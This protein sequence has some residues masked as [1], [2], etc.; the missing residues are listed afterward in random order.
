MQKLS[1]KIK[2]RD[3]TASEVQM[4]LNNS[5][6]QLAKFSVS[7]CPKL[8]LVNSLKSGDMYK[9]TL[10]KEGKTKLSFNAIKEDFLSKMKNCLEDRFTDANSDVIRASAIANLAL[11]P[12][13]ESLEDF[14]S[15]HVQTLAN[16]F[17]RTLAANG[18]NSDMLDSEWY[19][20]K[21][22]VKSWRKDYKLSK[23][24]DINSS[25]GKDHQNIL[26]LIDL[27]RV[28]PASSA[29]CERGFSAMKRTKTD[30]RAKLTSKSL[31]DLLTVALYSPDIK[32]FD[33]TRA[34]DLWWEGSSLS[35]RPQQSYQRKKF[36]DHY[37]SDETESEDDTENNDSGNVLLAFSKEYE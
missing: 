23:W 24:T 33:P 37:S 36:E 7:P 2:E 30:W 14:G 16:S 25:H 9:N 13:D 17:S 21:Q 5:L 22:V 29:E 35:R 3:V 6:G 8:S 10:L 31:T 27:C 34:I 18:I 15:D 28:I 4:C 20:L 1:L 11:W 32:E 26:A 19:S 12:N